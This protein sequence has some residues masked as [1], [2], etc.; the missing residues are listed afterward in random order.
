MLIPACF[1]I[2][3]G[4][5]T[6]F[7]LWSSRLHLASLFIVLI[8]EWT[9]ERSLCNRQ[10]PMTGVTMVGRYMPRRRGRWQVCFVRPTRVYVPGSLIQNLKTES[11]VHSIILRRLNRQAI[12]TWT[13]CIEAVTLLICCVQ[14]RSKDTQD[15][16]SKRTV[17]VTKYLSGLGS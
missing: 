13:E 7:G 1:P 14:G 4:S 8:P 5:I 16:G 3:E 11:S 15:A 12:L 9:L 6:T 17:I 10:Y 2:T